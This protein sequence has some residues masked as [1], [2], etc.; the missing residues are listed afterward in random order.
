MP[1]Q[2]SFIINGQS[3]IKEEIL[4]P[5]L[6]LE[7]F[8]PNRRSIRRRGGS[9]FVQLPLCGEIRE[10]IEGEAFESAENISTNKRGSRI[11]GRGLTR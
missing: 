2:E 11:L 3:V 7:W 8:R 1:S 6:Q 10:S 9:R 4:L 5:T